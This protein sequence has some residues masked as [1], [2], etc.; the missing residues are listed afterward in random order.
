MR[1]SWLAVNTA[2]AGVILRLWHLL[3]FKQHLDR[4]AIVAVWLGAAFVLFLVARE[5][6]LGTPPD[7]RGRLHRW[8]AAVRGVPELSLVILLLVLVFL[9]HWGFQR[10]ASDGREYFV[11]VRSLVI[12]LDLDLS[13]EN[14]AFG[15][16]GTA[17][18]YPFG[19]PL[20][21]VPFFLAA[22]GWL[23]LINLAGSAHPLNGFFNP[24]QRAA[25]LGSLLYGFAALVLIYGVLLKYF[26]RRL[27]AA[28]VIA[29]TCGS[30]I[31]WYLVVDNS[32]SHGASMFSVTLFIYVWLQGRDTESVRRW[33]L[34]GA[35]AGLMSMVRWQNVLFVA[36]LAVPELL[37]M[38]RRLV[39]TR[40]AKRR[41]VPSAPTLPAL[42]RRY[43]AFAGSFLIVFSP[44]LVAWRAIRGAWFA[45][46]TAAHGTQFWSPP[47]GDVLFSPDR[48][49]FSWTPLLLLS[50]LGLLAFARRQPR[51]AG[52]FFLGL[53]LQ[54]YINATVDWSGHGF[55]ARRFS[56][57]AVIFAVGVAA[58]LHWMRRRPALGPALLTATL[59]ALNILFMT[60]MFAGDVPPTGTVR[61]EQMVAAGTRR[62]GNPFALPM[63]ALT[64]L[65]F[66]A[67]MG[68]YERIGA[69]TFNN[70]RI[71]V[72]G[73]ND[74]RFLLR[75]FS[76]SERAGNASFR[77]SEGP[78]STLVVPLKEAAD[79]V[80]EFRAAGFAQPELGIQVVALWVNNELAERVG[81]RAA[82][83]D[84]RVSIPAELLRSGF[85]EIRFEYA[86]TTSPAAS[87]ASGDNRELAVR[88]ET[89]A[90]TRV[91]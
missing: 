19:T 9:F 64:A 8:Y 42:V 21:W 76:G 58:L 4:P 22:H 65:R 15:V 81:V 43:S 83:D 60:G 25:G 17:G 14:A 49:L 35:T 86:W 66:D 74:Q 5:M 13:N 91:G 89:I 63:S 61:F 50:A 26:S 67:D 51:L 82:P 36:L 59:V 77:W 33:A 71:D 3:L 18:N 56:N 54:V 90:F 57:C 69:Q 7:D 80:L 53:A 52:L 28:S 78:E 6:A 30:F 10:A 73:A 39:A 16:R 31:V 40:A 62:L 79:Y 48:G 34:L 75:G 29:L 87:G 85:N 27:A 45:P 32:M 72:G 38:A 44:Q 1:V 2:L 47:I 23:W 55:G 46:P 88:F 68:F 37:S 20:L 84:Y 12:D 70:L 41:P 11:Q 24:Y